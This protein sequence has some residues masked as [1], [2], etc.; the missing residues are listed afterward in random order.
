MAARDDS[1][2]RGSL[3]ACMI[4]LVLSLALNYFFWRWGNVQSIE[5]GDI[6]TKYDNASTLIREQEGKLLTLHEMLGVRQMSEDKFKSLASTSSGDADMDLIAKNFVRDMSYFPA[7][8]AAQQRNYSELPEFFVNAVRDRTAQYTTA[9]KEQQQIRSQADSDVQNARKAQQVAEDNRKSAD[10]KLKDEVDLFTQDRERMNQEKEE[11][12]DSLTKTVREFTGYRKKSAD[13]QAKLKQRSDQLVN[14]IETQRTQLN[15]LRSDKFESTQ[16]EV[17]FVSQGGNVCT[18]NLGAADDLR[19]GVTFGVIDADETRLDD[20]KVKA[21]IQVTKIR[22]AH[23]AEARVVALPLVSSPIIDGDKIYSPF[24]KSGVTVKIALAGDI[25]ID[26]D[27]KADNEQIKGMITSAGA[28]VAATVASDGTVD[29]VL[30]ATIRFLVIGQAPEISE[31]ADSAS[32]E[33]AAR[34]AAAMGRIKE[35]A[36]ELG[37]TVIPA[38]KLQAY[39]KTIDDSVTTPLGSAVRSEDFGPL[40]RRGSTRLPSDLPSLYKNDGEKTQKG[41]KLED[42]LKP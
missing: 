13:E 3:I 21:T 37:L 41:D 18:I 20:A 36:T 34:T 35:K 5:A 6:K 14:T 23:V 17:V 33:Q 12:R 42:I 10:K 24:W 39:L 29:G 2:I 28:Q 1:V 22:G 19:P 30:D 25:D 11:T 27:G 26:D 7:D 16:G 40:S 38:W 4:L 15:R 9:T 32:A 31:K 8:V